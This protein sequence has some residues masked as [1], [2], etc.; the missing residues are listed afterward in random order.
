MNEYATIVYVNDTKAE[1]DKRIDDLYKLLRD[2]QDDINK[3]LEGLASKDDLNELAKQLEL[4]RNDTLKSEDIH[5]LINQLRDELKLKV[6]C[7]VYDQHV[8][9]YTAT[10]NHI[11]SLLAK[12]G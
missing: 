12:D 3:K 9:N 1:L 6:D 10:I 11:Y 5:A 7:D 4:L 2:L 8:A